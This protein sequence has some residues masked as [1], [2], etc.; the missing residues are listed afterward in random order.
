MKKAV[1]G[2]TKTAI[3]EVFMKRL[4]GLR[5]TSASMLLVFCLS[6]MAWADQV[7]YGTGVGRKLGRG[8]GNLAFGWMELLKGIQ[9]VGDNQNFIAGLTWG[10]IYGAGNTIVREAV[11]AYEVLTF[12]IPLPENFKPILQPEFVLAGDRPEA[13]D[14]R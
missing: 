12:P 11:G 7:D 13:P 4:N 10:P 1:S 3:K 14:V 2:E 8:L 5:I 9:E 6:T